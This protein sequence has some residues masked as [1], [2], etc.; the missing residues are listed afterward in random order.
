MHLPPP[1]KSLRRWIVPEPWRRLL[2]LQ[3]P[4]RLAIRAGTGRFD[5]L[6]ALFASLDAPFIAGKH[7]LYLP[8]GPAVSSWLAEYPPSSGLKIWIAPEPPDAHLILTANLLFE[9]Q[10]G[11]RIYDQAR[12][13]CGKL[14][15]TAQVI[16]HIEGREPQPGEWEGARQALLDLESRRLLKAR[17]IPGQPGALPAKAAPGTAIFCE[18]SRHVRYLPFHRLQVADYGAYLEGLAQAAA[19]QT[20]FGNLDRRNR[21]YLYQSIPGVSLPAKRR[22]EPRIERVRALLDEARVTFRDRVVLDIGCN[23]GMM[24][25]QYLKLEAR[26][27]QGWDLASV[28]PHAERMLG[29]LGCTRFS[30]TG[31]DLSRT[32]PLDLPAFLR[33]GSRGCAISYLAIRGHVGWLDALA[34]IPWAILIYEGHKSDSRDD[35]ERHLAELRSRV[36]FEH[37]PI[38][39]YRDGRRSRPRLMT[40]LVRKENL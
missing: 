24:M 28:T 33:A 13:S 12:L 32:Q 17:T 14:E 16:E 3:A 23:L 39:P 4:R 2:P 38:E 25:A 27:C 11:P 22:I 34:S 40:V 1:F 29:A 21:R 31:G 20:H 35:L 7:W 6:E 9:Q 19:Q 36:P 26:W 37:G 18:R 5:G 15:F 8:P 10:L 30:F